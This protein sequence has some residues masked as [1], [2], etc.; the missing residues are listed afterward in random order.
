MYS[1]TPD[2]AKFLHRLLNAL[3][4]NQDGVAVVDQNG[5][6]QTTYREL[7]TIACQV[8]GYLQE[9]QYL[10]HSFIG[11]CLP[12]S[13]EYVAA[14]LGIWMAGHA[15]VPMGDSFP[16]YRIDYIMNHCGSPLLIDED[17]F[18]EIM[19]TA[20]AQ[21]MNLPKEDDVMALFYTSGSTGN[22]KGVIHTFR[23][24][25]FSEFILNTLQGVKP[26]VMGM[27]LSM[28][29]V[30]SEYML[31]SLAVGGKIVIVPPAIIKDI[32]K[33]EDFYKEH[34]VTYAFFTPSLLKYFRGKSSCL[35]LVMVASERVSNIAPD[36]YRLINIYGQTETAEGCFM[37]DIDKA[38]DNT[39]IGKPT[40][41]HL[42]YKILDDDLNEVPSGE[43]G[44]LCLRGLL[45]PG[46]Y[47]DPERTSALWRGGWLHTGDIVRQLSDGNVVYVNRKDWMVKINGQRVEPG[48]VETAIR[49]FKGVENVVVKGF[50]MSDRQYLCAYYVADGHVTN[51]GLRQ[52]LSS[53]LPAYMVPAYFVRMNQ[54]PLL[55]NG[56]TDRNSLQPPVRQ[57]SSFADR[58]PYRPPQNFVEQ[59]LCDVFSATLNVKD[60]GVDDDFFALGGDSIRVMEVQSLCSELSLTAR[61]VYV[62]RTPSKIAEVLSKEETTVYARQPDYVLSQTQLGI[63]SECM[64]RQGETVY[65][66]GMLFRL[67]TGI[68][69][70]RLAK[71]CEAVV[72]AHPYVK[73]R[74]F[75]DNEGNPRQRPNDDEMYRQDIETVDDEEFETLKCRLVQPFNL[76]HDRLFRIRIFKTPS[77]AYLFMDFHHI[78]FDGTS[79]GILIMDI[80]DAYRGKVLEQETWSGFEVAQEEEAL[81]LSDD[82]QKAATWNKAVFGSLDISSLPEPDVTPTSVAYGQQLLP[83][84]ITYDQLLEACRQLGVTPHV[85]TLAAFGYVLG[86]FT[87]A[88]ESLFAT[89]YNGRKDLKTAR[90]VAMMV[91]TLAVHAHWDRAM[92]LHQYLQSVKRQQLESMNNDLF[93]FAE[94]SAMNRCINSQV[95]FAYQGDIEAVDTICGEPVE[96]F[97][98]MKSQTGEALLLELSCRQQ[99]LHLRAEYQSSRFSQSFVNEFLC[100]YEEV[101]GQFLFSDA[102]RLVSD[103]P[104]V[105]DKEKNDLIKL[106]TGRTLEYDKNKTIVSLL[107]DVTLRQPHATA[108]IYQDKR[109]TYQELDNLTDRL[110]SYLVSHYHLQQ[111]EVV[112]VMIDRSELLV[113]YPLAILKAGAAYMP[114]DYN[115]PASRL[116]YMCEEAG[117]RL[118]MS[119]GQRVLEALPDYKGD[120]FLAEDLTTISEQITDLPVPLTWHRF[121]V[122][123]TSGTMGKPKGVMLEHHSLVNYCLWYADELRLSADDCVM[124]NSNFGF[125]A[126]MIDIYP[127]LIAGAAV[128]IIPNRMRLDMPLLNQ[129]MEEQHIT[130]GFMTTQMG[131]LFVT[132]MTNT[133]LRVLTVGGEKLMP[134]QL[135]PYQLYNLYGPTECTICVSYYHV[136]HD[137][138]RPLIGRPLPNHQLSIVNADMQYVPRGVTGELIVRGQ[139][140]GRSYL[141][142]STPSDKF[143]NFEGKRSYRTGDI[144]RWTEDGNLEYLGRVDQQVKLHGLRIELEEIEARALQHPLISQAVACVKTVGGDDNLCL[145][146]VPKSPDASVDIGE[147]KS[148]LAETLATFMVPTFI[149][150]QDCLPMTAN[151]KINRKALPAP[152]LVNDS[153]VAPETEMEEQLFEL[154][155]EQLRTTRFGVTDNLTFLGLSSLA[156][157]RLSA[158]LQKRFDVQVK[159]SDV[160][161]HPTVRA[162]AALLTESSDSRLPVYEPRTYYPLM[163]NQ[164]GLYLEWEKN[165]DTTQY[166]IPFVYRFYGI[167][168]DRMVEALRRTVN[169]HP[170]LKSRLVKAD[171]QICLKRQDEE[172]VEVFVREESIEPDIAYFCQC[173][174]PFNLL[175]GQLYHIEVI[176]TPSFVYVLIDFHHI[177]F[178]GLSVDVFMSDLKN[179]YDGNSLSGETI[180]A[181]DYALYEKDHY[182]EAFMSEA[183]QR[184]DVLLADAQVFSCSQSSKPDGLSIVTLKL[185][186]P[187]QKI[188]T[189]CAVHHVTVNSYMHAA[190]NETIRRLSREEKLVYLTVDNGREAGAELMQCVGMFVKTLLMVSRLHDT[191]S[192]SAPAYVQEVQRQLQEAYE[193]D[194]YPLTRIVERHN[195][196][197]EVMFAYQGEL[198]K[199]RSFD[200]M[201]QIIVEPD[202]PKFPVSIMITPDGDDY[203]FVIEYDGMRYDRQ[204]MQRLL[205]A[206]SVVATQLTTAETIGE[207]ELISSDT[208]AS[209]LKLGT[210]PVLDYDQSVT[211]VSLFRQQVDNVPEAIAV[212][213]EQGSITYRELDRQS[214]ILAAILVGLGVVADSFVCIM[215]P[216]CKEFLVS[217]LA[218]FKA[219][220]AYVPLDSDIPEDRLLFML[221][222][223]Q[224]PVLLTT[225][226]LCEEKFSRGYAPVENTVLID[227]IDFT[228]ES[229]ALDN[230][231]PSSLAYMI[232]TSGSTGNPKGVMVTHAAMMNF[233]VWLAKTEDLKPGEQCAIHT[234]F[235]FDGSLFDLFPPLMS[236]ATLHVL[237]ASMRVNLQSMCRYFE[238]NHIVGLLL[239]TQIGMLIMS[240]YDLPLRF[241]MVGGEKLTSFKPSSMKLFN[242]YGPTEFAVCSSFHLID[243]NR[244]YDN[245]PIG[246]PVPNSVAAVVDS[247]GHLLPRGFAGELCLLGRQMAKGYWNHP[248]LTTSHFTPCPFIPEETMYHTGDLVRWNDD[249]DLEYLGRIDSQ[250]KIRGYRIEL[251]EIEKKMMGMAEV[252]SAAAVVRQ[253]RHLQ[254]LVGYYTTTAPI[255]AGVMHN[256]LANKLPDY[257]VPQLLIQLKSMPM[258]LNGK[259]DRKKL[260][261]EDYLSELVVSKTVAPMTKDEHILFNLACM[262]L[263]TNDFGVTD[264]LT[265]MGMNSLLSIKLAEMAR[266]SGLLVKVN[267]ILKYKSVRNILFH[268]QSIGTWEEGYDSSKPVVVLIQG[269]TSYKNLEPL[270][271]R[272]CTHYSVFA[273]ETIGDHFDVLFNEKELTRNDVVEFYLDFLEASLPHTANVELFMGHSFG[274]ELAYRCAVRWQQKTGTSPKVC[275]FDTFSHV[276][277]IVKENRYADT[278]KQ[279]MRLLRS[280]VDEIPLPGYEGDVTYF[281]AL[282][283][284]KYEEEKRE[285]EHI[286]KT[287]I[288][289]IEI[290]PIAAG[291]FSMLD[292]QYCDEYV[293]IIN[294]SVLPHQS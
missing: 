141:S 198:Q 37:F 7:Y 124:A 39:P 291:H 90:T 114:L 14:E 275:L 271:G 125:D 58:P 248:E 252:T 214:D 26:L 106:G 5:R 55:P 247:Q 48:E 112:G 256:H 43:E 65:N 8:V 119:E 75:V 138:N 230:S 137:Y 3:L 9:K 194:G 268:D 32:R 240:H 121:I 76:L 243:N 56:K 254:Y 208:Q 66:N 135:P 195:I 210:G 40:M 222:D 176:K 41:D 175:G 67:G 64:S 144:V 2:T 30:V 283:V 259:I 108:V 281:K 150:K 173:I 251:E 264:D 219:G 113:I 260:K 71:A 52:F 241:L 229:R 226:Q 179:A 69:L 13:M 91:K 190:F 286:W 35:Q 187:R 132:N 45:S 143:V 171:G 196:Y 165:S 267:D 54:L 97:S 50:T 188:D 221:A 15:I 164:R 220:G 290:H 78:I 174:R 205:S 140:V 225:R 166:N 33:L 24:F 244:K 99:E 42:E 236:G 16:S 96:E 81:R 261:Y 277:N 63:F 185:S 122:L 270:I 117:V 11:I 84:H 20:P 29:F 237:S 155:A 255:S 128:C 159:M 94:M 120:V 27:T 60:V 200:N 181:F 203:S 123:Y 133:S 101:L 51:V 189:F 105:S 246:R 239:T 209:L 95:L 282:N 193:M 19:V 146:Y 201:K 249:G 61:N 279:T 211:F 93:S 139:G 202:L 223:S 257:M 216:R 115:F 153:F 228:V 126:H 36:G 152:L 199:G 44:E 129:Y 238:D 163:E 186:I 116:S 287:L 169:A 180:Q 183:D 87:Y 231:S 151:G 118:I 10:P 85:L 53:R 6:R 272:L 204:Q 167:D 77:N 184:M 136:T 215:L 258:T 284:R 154:L 110:A 168:A 245:I 38:Y 250:V 233:L 28:F 109:L 70:S 263:E 102:D 192:L 100:C 197:A 157:M 182:D 17:T 142:F 262:V 62:H 232:Y 217:V 278:D 73:M 134:L 253:E 131:Y 147:L 83:L 289:Q 72:A 130:V 191:S 206:V 273:I 107:R 172:E 25:D 149:V 266:Q 292:S 265:L 31:A 47:K 12:S 98:L 213:D 4:S 160:M 49:Q 34:G 1:I 22:P 293:R 234:S 269:F 18:K 178:D 46:Y 80:N 89:I 92:T 285:D 21:V 88:R 280:L 148:F 294:N 218:V 74:L 288:P 23:T 127:T 57:E 212:V 59:K 276:E 103:I 79:M 170:Y 111:E 161:R 68:D 162:I 274:G 207:I 177:I 145:Y 235:V 224:T 82:Y 227:E 242:C 86:S 158:V 104:L 156:A